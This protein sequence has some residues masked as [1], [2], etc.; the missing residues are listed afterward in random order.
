MSADEK[1]TEA[2]IEVAKDEH[3][4]DETTHTK[5]INKAKAAT[6]NQ[7]QMSLWQEIRKYPKAVGWSMLISLCIAMEGFDLCLSNTFYGLPQFRTCTQGYNP[8]L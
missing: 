1:G 3:A 4:L 5:T 6:D 7:H 2:G 8:F